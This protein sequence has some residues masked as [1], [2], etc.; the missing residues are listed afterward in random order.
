MAV[1]L[2]QNPRS[3]SVCWDVLGSKTKFRMEETDRHVSIAKTDKSDQEGLSPSRAKTDRSAV[4]PVSRART[5]K[6]EYDFEE[7]SPTNANTEHSDVGKSPVSRARTDK[8]DYEFEESPTHHKAGIP[9][10]ASPV[11]PAKTDKSEYEFED[12]SPTNST[13]GS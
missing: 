4:S 13:L 8:S 6:S 2:L 3:S 11:S 9:D 10:P 1:L 7:Y 12:M 5:D